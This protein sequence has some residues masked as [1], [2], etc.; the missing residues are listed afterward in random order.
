MLSVI[1]VFLRISKF[2]LQFIVVRERKKKPDK[3]SLHE[4]EKYILFYQLILQIEIYIFRER[5]KWP[6]ENMAPGHVLL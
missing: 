4:G 3:H 6:P 1:F 2:I 5:T